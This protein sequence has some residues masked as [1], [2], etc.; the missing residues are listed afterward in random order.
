MLAIFVRAFLVVLFVA[1]TAAAQEIDYARPGI[2]VGGGGTFAVQDF[3]YA[4]ANDSLGLNARVGYRINETF[5]AELEFE[6]YEDF[7]QPDFF[8]VDGY[9]ISANGKAYLGTG[10]FQPYALLGVGLLHG[11]ISDEFDK[12]DSDELAV[13]IGLGADLY[14]TENVVMTFDGAYVLPT[15]DLDDFPFLSFSWGLAWRS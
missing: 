2:Y 15:G 1:T 12:F 4:G 7:G 14:A 9:S 13:R 5:A 8:E 11:E 6:W 10:Q 3:D